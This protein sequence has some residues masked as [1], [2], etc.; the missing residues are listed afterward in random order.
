MKQNENLNLAQQQ[1]IMIRS[2]GHKISAQDGDQV[3]EDGLLPNAV[4][5]KAKELRGFQESSIREWVLYHWITHD[6]IQVKK[7]GK[8]FFF[9][10]LDN[11]DKENLTALGYASF[12]G[13]LFLFMV[14]KPKE[15]Y[16]AHIFL[17]APIWVKV[18]GLPL[19]YNET[20]IAR[21][22]LQRIGRVLY[23]DNSSTS[24][25]FEN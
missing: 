10:Y 19:L 8:L 15:S 11:R 20:H 7:V 2:M 22:A 13:A 14:C 21:R 24:Q 4:I 12:Q 1:N 18:E 17:H 9:F 3:L 23:F 25:R 16:H 6:E 5:G